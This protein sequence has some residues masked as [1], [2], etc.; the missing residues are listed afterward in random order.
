MDGLA[1][2]AT[3]LSSVNFSNNSW[4]QSKRVQTKP[5]NV[6]G[7]CKVPWMHQLRARPCLSIATT[8]RSK[9]TPDICLLRVR[10]SGPRMPAIL[11]RLSVLGCSDAK[12]W[13]CHVL[14]SKKHGAR[15]FMQPAGQ[16]IIKDGPHTPVRMVKADL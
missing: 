10:F 16:A 6:H 7:T 4:D 3:N 15:S 11:P 9:S 12:T 13:S 14:P 2:S 1:P 8:T 5:S